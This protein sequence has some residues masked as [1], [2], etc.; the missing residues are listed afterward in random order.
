MFWHES[1]PPGAEILNASD[2]VQVLQL[3]EDNGPKD[4]MPESL[5]SS[6]A[7]QF[8]LQALGVTSASAPGAIHAVKLIVPLRWG[9]IARSDIIPLRLRDSQYIEAAFSFAEPLQTYTG[10]EV[11]ISSSTD[12]TT[13]FSAAT[14]GLLLFNDS[15]W[16]SDAGYE[17]LSLAVESDLENKLSFS[18]IQPG[19]LQRKT[20][21]LV[22]ANSSHPEDGLGFYHAA[23]ELGIKVVVLENPGHWLED[24]A[25][26]HWRDAFIPTR[27]TNPP[28]EDV[29]DHILASI[30]HMASRWT[31][32]SLLLT[33]SGTTSL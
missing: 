25:Y 19:T 1:G 5:G 2:D 30:R 29:G 4:I 13:L 8:L 16:S 20:L 14:A 9:Y 18:W 22:D 26:T 15:K 17:A 32:S 6:K 24:P 10:E 11:S 33:R 7:F 31:E 12:L 27:L 28:E 3:D 23:K 21:A